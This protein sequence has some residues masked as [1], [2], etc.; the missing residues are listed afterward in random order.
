MAKILG[1][2]MD[3]KEKKLLVNLVSTFLILLSACL[4]I[5]LLIILRFKE[6]CPE[7]IV[8]MLGV[9]ATLYAP[10]AAFFF[11]DSWKDQK[12]YELEKEYAGKILEL[13]NYFD[14]DTHNKYSATKSIEELLSKN[15]LIL[16]NIFPSSNLIGNKIAE[17]HTYFNTFN[18]LSNKKIDKEY[19]NDFEL[20][21]VNITAQLN[22]INVYLSL[23]LDDIPKTIKDR[24]L[25]SYSKQA[26]HPYKNKYEE[27]FKTTLK[28]K[29]MLEY[30]T[31]GV[32]YSKETTL[33]ELKNN[34]DESY[35]K[36]V[37]ELSKIIKI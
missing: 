25:I 37:D 8:G 10:L 18:L 20:Y 35:K 30:T 5:A 31:A 14:I 28:E 15:Q 22:I 32:E 12:N 33:E 16:K 6:S 9:C 24:N 19:M 23:Y 29:I 1:G 11:Y 26:F 7:V 13:V 4:F 2:C 21:A 36:L 34:Y 27:A 17:I 3:D